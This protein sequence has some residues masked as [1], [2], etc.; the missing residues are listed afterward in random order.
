[1]SEK[2]R[3]DHNRFRCLTVAFRASPEE[4]EQINF[5]V[6]LTGLTKRE[7]IISKLLDR[8]I[9]VQGNCKVHRAVY[10]RLTEV[11]KE[12]QRIQ[13]GEQVDDELMDNIKLIT[14]LVDSLYIK[15]NL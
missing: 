6:S 12:L 3:D 9:N 4:N 2:K 1:M 5:A 10:D 15:T 14:N 13:T 11:L 7:Y 8:T